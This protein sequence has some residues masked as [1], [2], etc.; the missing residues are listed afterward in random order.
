MTSLIFVIL[1]AVHF[2]TQDLCSLRPAPILPANTE[3]LIAA[4][5]ASLRMTA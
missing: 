3:I 1:R 4:N 5:G 2:G